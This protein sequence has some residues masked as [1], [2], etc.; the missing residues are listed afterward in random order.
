MMDG[1]D[2]AKALEDER[3]ERRERIATA[4][5]AAIISKGYQPH[6]GAASLEAVELADALMEELDK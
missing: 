3:R 1:L 5:L 4:V 6:R 2:K